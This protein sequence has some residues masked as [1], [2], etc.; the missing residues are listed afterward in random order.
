[1]AEVKTESV[2]EVGGIRTNAILAEDSFQFS[3]GPTRVLMQV[4][5]DTTTYHR[6]EML[7]CTAI[8]TNVEDIVVGFQLWAVVE[9]PGGQIISPAYGPMEKSIEAN[10]TLIEHMSQQI[11]NK[12]PYGGPY[13]YTVRIGTYE[14]EVLAEDSF[15][16]FIV[17]GVVHQ[18]P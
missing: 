17:P 12:A 9:T 15:E 11:P 8:I 2:A 14:E 16:F 7:G 13:I 10:G 5:P 6:G 1:M 4:S 18:S 3:V